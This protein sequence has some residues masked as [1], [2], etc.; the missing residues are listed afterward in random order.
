MIN[1]SSMVKPRSLF[2][3]SSLS[4]VYPC[5]SK[6]DAIRNTPLNRGPI[7]SG[8]KR[9]GHGIDLQ[10]LDKRKFILVKAV[11]DQ[12]ERGDKRSKNEAFQEGLRR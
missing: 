4:K 9:W 5:L 8:I 2:I 1:S 3:A 10:L 11:L 6:K 7:L 12:D